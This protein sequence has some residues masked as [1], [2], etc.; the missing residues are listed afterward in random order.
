MIT[1]PRGAHPRLRGRLAPS[2]TGYLHIGNARSFLLAWLEMRALGGEI[3]LRIEDLDQARAVRDAAEGIVRD[4]RWLGLD[5]DNELGPDYFQSNRS[6]LYRA[7]IE[8]LRGRDLVYECYCSRKELRDLANA[9]HGPTGPIYP[10]TCRDLPE[11]ERRLQ[12]ERKSPS[13]RFRT[14]PDTVVEFRDRVAGDLREDIAREAGDFIVARAD[15]VVSYQL[16][17]VVDD[18]A[19]GITHVLRGDDLLPS[20]ARQILLFRTL[21]AEPPSYCHVPLV[22]APDGTRLAKRHG[23]ISVAELRAAGRTPEELTGWLAWSCGLRPTSE[24]CAARELVA[25]FSTE[26]ISH[27]PTV[28]RE[29][30][31]E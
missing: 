7:T 9:P 2:P 27:A 8:R 20:T 12:R 26:K 28:L 29:L 22:L 17:V 16:A 18:I 5:W 14:P 25:D 6:A 19:M 30:G 1:G 31:I 11:D 15:G 13:L 23:S 3:I 4:L 10:G 21:G 24:P